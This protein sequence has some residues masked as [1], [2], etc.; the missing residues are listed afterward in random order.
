MYPIA[1]G[2]VWM[3]IVYFAIWFNVE[4]GL[5]LFKWYLCRHVFG[6]WNEH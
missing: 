6:I 5:N 1:P 2:S 4:I 3:T